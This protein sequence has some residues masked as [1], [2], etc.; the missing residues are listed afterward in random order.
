MKKAGGKWLGLALTLAIV[1]L[2]GACAGKQNANSQETAPVSSAPAAETKPAEAQPDPVTL[3]VSWW[4]TESRHTALLNAIELYAGKYPHVKIEA[5]YMGFDG[6]LQKLVTQFAGGTA[7]DVVFVNSSMFSQIGDFLLDLQPYGELDTSAIPEAVIR[8]FDYYEGRHLKV[9]VGGSANTTLINTGFFTRTGLDEN[10][11]WTW[12]KLLEEGERIHREFPDSYLTTGDLDV[13]D[14]IFFRPYILQKTNNKW[15]NDDHT[16]G[17]NRELLVEG[18]TYISNLFTSG[19]MEPFG[20]A[21]AFIGKMEQNP[22]W[23]QNNIGILLDVS[24]A[25]TKYK[26]ANPGSVLKAKPFPEHPGSLQ[27]ANPIVS[28]SGIAVNKETKYKEEAVKFINWF[29]NDPEAAIVKGVPFGPPVSG[30]ALQALEE[31]GALDAD[32]VAALNFAGAKPTSAP[33][34]ISS[35][36]ELGQINKDEIQK[37]AFGRTTPEKAADEILK[38]YASKLEELKKQ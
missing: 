29:T 24:N 32:I 11:V 16:V 27:S 12:E 36:P 23:L 6:Y 28:G 10:I 34:V 19:T 31:A 13:I 38:Q 18:L 20:E 15:V 8:D 37:I 9:A 25:I 5:E 22:R 4:G 7:P 1:L 30:V 21:Q 33:N 35:N 3:R 2:L 26:E 17:F 14:L